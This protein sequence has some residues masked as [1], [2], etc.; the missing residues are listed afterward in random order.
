MAVLFYSNL[1]VLR[2]FPCQRFLKIAGVIDKI[3]QPE[4]AVLLWFFRFRESEL[5]SK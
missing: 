1:S 3:R 4:I 5:P 2:G